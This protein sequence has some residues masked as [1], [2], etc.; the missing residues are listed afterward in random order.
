VD[1]S[2]KLLILKGLSDAPY[3]INWLN[4]WTGDSIKTN[5]RASQ[6]GQWIDQIPRL[7]QSLSDIAFIIRPAE[8]GNIP[9]RLELMAYPIE[10]YADTSYMSQIT[11]FVLDAQG[12][13]CFQANNSITFKLDGPGTLEGANPIVPTNGATNITFRANSTA[14]TVRIIASSAGLVADTVSLVIQKFLYIDDF[15]A[16]SSDTELVNVWQ[17][18][19]GTDANVFLESSVVGE[20]QQAMRLEYKI[21]DGSLTYSGISRSLIGDWSK[22]NFLTLWLKPNS[23]GHTLTIRLYVD[24][25]RYWY[26]IY[27]LTGTDRL[28]V[29]IP[30]NDFK[31]NYSAT[32]LDRTALVSMALY[33]NQGSGNWGSGTLYFDS[34][35]FL[36]NYAAVKQ[37]QNVQ[38]L[39]ETYELYQNYPNP[40]NNATTI[41]YALPRSGYVRIAAYNIQGQLVEL[42][43][44]KRQGA[45]IYRIQWSTKNISSGI[46]FY[47]MET[48]GIVLVQKCILLK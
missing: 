34:F 20:G 11:C 21:G 18:R 33:I 39:P 22:A 40:F 48:E 24:N 35:K 43:V 17:K 31:A 26:Y 37:G 8:S 13:M 10:L 42:L 4:P 47:R 30:L 15:E 1:V 28:T 2:G 45:G 7:L 5:S 23:S 14:G 36:S 9:Q 16:Y 6:N 27:T 41:S 12:R 25:T 46:Y 44:D 3:S 29:T 19:Y 32:Y 38:Q